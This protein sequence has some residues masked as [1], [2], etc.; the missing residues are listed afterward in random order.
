MRKNEFR[1]KR[2]ADG[3]W[4]CGQLIQG[5]LV[6]KLVNI[7]ERVDATGG[8]TCYGSHDVDPDTVCQDIMM[9]DSCGACIFEN[10][11]VTVSG[12]KWT[13]RG[14]IHYDS[15]EGYFTLRFSDGE[16]SGIS[17]SQWMKANVVRVIGNVFDN[18]EMFEEPI[19]LQ[20]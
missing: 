2:I 12:D 17:L 6:C 5:N 14:K 13:V 18:P 19:I 20:K 3:Q 15:A 9:M 10:D 8:E 11:I 1:G 4:V 16:T 7:Y